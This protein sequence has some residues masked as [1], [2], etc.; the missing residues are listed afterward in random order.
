MSLE[1]ISQ[2]LGKISGVRIECPLFVIASLASVFIVFF[3]Y[4]HVHQQ[5]NVA[6]EEIMQDPELNTL[7]KV[8]LIRDL[9]DEA[10]GKYNTL[11]VSLFTFW[12]GYLVA[13]KN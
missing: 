11:L 1:K 6:V 5:T 4:F 3:N 8:E 10:Y 12:F 9:Q 7:E 2:F 13:E